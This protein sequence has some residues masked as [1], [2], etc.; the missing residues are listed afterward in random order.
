MELLAEFAAL[1]PH[2]F[3][4]RLLNAAKGHAVTEVILTLGCPIRLVGFC[5]DMWVQ[6]TQLDADILQQVLDAACGYSLHAVQEQLCQG[7]VTLP[8]GCRLGV[9]GQ[10][11]IQNGQMT[12]LTAP[13]SLHLR[14][15]TQQPGCAELFVQQMFQKGL[16]SVLL[17]GPPASGKTTLLKDAVRC[18]AER[19]ARLSVMDERREMQSLNGLPIDLLTGYPKAV[20][21]WQAIRCMAPQMIVAD[22]IGSLEEAQAVQRGAVCGVYT[23]ATAHADSIEHLL[24]RQDLAPLLQEGI[25]HKICLLCPAPPGQ[26]KGVYAKSQAGW[27]MVGGCAP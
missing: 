14:L 1:L 21:L 8:N 17:A 18:L 13:Q 26:I 12:G 9:C 23:L 15:A 10:A 24:A 11:V 7:F 2:P 20:G 16:C 27:Q 25:F 3:G 5:L 6:E 19:G 22:E 4:H